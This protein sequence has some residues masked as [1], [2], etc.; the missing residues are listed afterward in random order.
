MSL[1]DLRVARCLSSL[2]ADIVWHQLST[3]NL[4]TE[5]KRDT[6]ANPLPP[7]KAYLYS[8]ESVAQMSFVPLGVKG[9]GR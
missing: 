1:T 6:W 7:Q 2:N 9:V 5:K 3:N 8:A 4:P